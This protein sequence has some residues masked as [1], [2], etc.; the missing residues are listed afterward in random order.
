MKKKAPF[1]DYPQIPDE[2]IDAIDNGKLLLFIGA[3]ISKLYGYPLWNELARDLANVACYERIISFSEREVLLDKNYNPQKVISII[4]KKFDDQNQKGKAGIDYLAG[5]LRNYNGRD[6]KLELRIA[7]YLS[8]YNAVI[9]TTN[10]DES[11]EGTEYFK[12][13]KVLYSMSD[14]NVNYKDY[15][16]VHI[17]GSAKKPDSMVFTSEKYAEIYSFESEVGKKIKELLNGE[18]TI[19]FIGY[20]IS[21]FELLRYFIKKEKGP[22]RLFK[23]DGY[24]YKDKEKLEL[25]KIYYE[26]LGVKLLPFSREKDDF[27][28]LIK[29]L[30]KWNSEIERRTFGPSLRREVI[31]NEILNK[32]PVDENIHT[33]NEMINIGEKKRLVVEELCHSIYLIEWLKCLKDNKTLFSP[34]INIKPCEETKNKNYR[35]VP[36][37]ALKII[38][39]YCERKINDNSVD[40]FIKN[41][42]NESISVYK[43]DN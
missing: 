23:I 22:Q 5:L 20:G 43:K 31:I 26:S 37:D 9:V 17:H 30:K 35:T 32:K 21:E 38:N 40:D 7:K 29:L 6:S 19:L 33:I 8:N 25:D 3:G 41:L 1:S 12:D 27:R 18:W 14:F 16:F 15:S 39:E 28:G 11:L 4:V 42:I 10:A 36:W 13:R 24:F 34:I 2:I